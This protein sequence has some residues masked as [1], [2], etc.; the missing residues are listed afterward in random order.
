ML[1]ASY[2]GMLSEAF[3]DTAMQYFKGSTL[4][5]KGSFA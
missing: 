2:T 5:C 3:L 1:I 4:C